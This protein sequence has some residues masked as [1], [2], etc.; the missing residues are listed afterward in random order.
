MSAPPQATSH[1]ALMTSGGLAPCL[2]SSVAYIVSAYLRAGAPFTLRLFHHSYMGILRGESTLVNPKTFNAAATGW[3]LA[4]G[5]L[6]RQAHQRCRLQE[7]QFGAR[8]RRSLGSRCA[9]AEGGRRERAPHIAAN[10][11]AAELST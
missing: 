10:T 5:E 4:D 6:P 8:V 11:Q 7:A 3:R 2:S 9:P 1:L